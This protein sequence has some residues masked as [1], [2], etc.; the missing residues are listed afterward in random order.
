M[1]RPFDQNGGGLTI[2]R[3]LVEDPARLADIGL[4]APLIKQKKFIPHLRPRLHDRIAMPWPRA[5][6]R[7][8]ADHH[9]RVGRGEEAAKLLAGDADRMALAEV[10]LIE[11]L[12]IRI[13]RGLDPGDVGLR[14]SIGSQQLALFPAAYTRAE[15]VFL[16]PRRN[17]WQRDMVPA[18]TFQ[19]VPREIGWME[20]VRDDDHSARFGVVE[21][22]HNRG[23]EALVD[24]RD[25]VEIAG[26][27]DI[28]R[29]VENDR[30][31][32]AAG[33][34]SIG[35]DRVDATTGG[36]REIQNALSILCQARRRKKSFVPGRS[37]RSSR[38]R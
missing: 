1:P 22:R 30:R 9:R 19:Y 34:R 15:I 29:V 24:F 6:A 18:A 13:E 26:I 27:V 33:D 23:V 38:T 14:K 10:L 37:V 35:R 4:R 25:L 8:D 12:E 11:R 3:S 2:G 17:E 16:I 31:R 32:A 28:E 36:R 20:A 7:V 5:M 21:P